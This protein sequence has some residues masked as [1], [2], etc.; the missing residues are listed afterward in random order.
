MNKEDAISSCQAVDKDTYS[1]RGFLYNYNLFLKD[2]GYH[3][4]YF[5]IPPVQQF[6]QEMSQ[7][8]SATILDLGSGIGLETAWM[9]SLVP[10]SQ[11]IPL[12]IST[13]GT[14]CGRHQL[15]LDQVQG[16]IT[17]P[18]FADE[19]FDGIHCK[20]ALVHVEDKPALIQNL[21]AIL[22]PGGLLI[23]VSSEYAYEGLMQYPWDPEE[24][25]L[26][27]QY[28]G[29]EEVYSELLEM[30]MDEWYGKVPRRF[31]VFQKNL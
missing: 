25:K 24:I 6:L 17:A 14:L 9:K 8:K 18:P 7:R 20:D 29:L 12:D 11:V 26:I 28:Y 10:G 22:K 4:Y 1:G 21:S 16:D 30:E 19:S 31:I 15:N 3:E 2:E 5:S 13:A 23:F 27:A